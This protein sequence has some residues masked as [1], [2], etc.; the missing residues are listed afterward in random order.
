MA[1][2]LNNV[3]G[4]FSL[5]LLLTWKIPGA[6]HGKTKRMRER[7]R[8]KDSCLSGMDFRKLVSLSGF[9]FSQEE[10]TY[11][12]KRMLLAVSVCCYSRF[13]IKLSLL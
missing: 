13:R 7:K 9:V 8:K 5:L 4:N 6:L 10:S 11:K 1:L 3:H 2:F 12:E